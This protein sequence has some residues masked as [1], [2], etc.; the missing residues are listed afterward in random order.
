MVS[1]DTEI[2]NYVLKYLREKHP[3]QY[4]RW[5]VEDVRVQPRWKRVWTW[6]SALCHYREDRHFQRLEDA[7][8]GLA[9]VRVIEDG[10]CRTY[11]W[12]DGKYV[13]RQGITKDVCRDIYGN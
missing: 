9:A 12:C 10:E 6:W 5:T 4:G 2:N 13:Y 11:E 3:D 7:P 8:D 1:F